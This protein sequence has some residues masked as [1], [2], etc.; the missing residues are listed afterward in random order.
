MAERF[1]IGVFRK[2]VDEVEFRP[3]N[4]NGEPGYA[5]LYHGQLHAVL[6]IRTDGRRILEVYSVLNPDKLRAVR[7]TAH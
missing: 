1:A 6:T 4:I 5:V 7:L 3:I 2:V